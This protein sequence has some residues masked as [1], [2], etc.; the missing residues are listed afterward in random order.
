M[1]VIAPSTFQLRTAQALQNRPTTE[2][3]A[4]DFSVHG[5]GVKMV[6][7]KLLKFLHEVFIGQH[8]SIARA[9]V[10]HDFLDHW[11][12]IDHAFDEVDGDAELVK[13]VLAGRWGL[14]IDELEPQLPAIVAIMT[15]YPMGRLGRYT[16]IQSQTAPTSNT[17]TERRTLEKAQVEES[18]PQRV[19][20]KEGVQ[21]SVSWG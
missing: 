7:T 16:K 5:P 15:G 18:L 2:A 4:L 21:N 8:L 14:D 6:E 17:I 9:H 13:R 3:L 12:E 11:S 1:S 20:L 19:V 10:R